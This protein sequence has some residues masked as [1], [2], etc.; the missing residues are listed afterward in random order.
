MATSHEEYFLG[1]KLYTGG[2]GLDTQRGPDPLP[3]C[4]NSS[5]KCT[6]HWSACQRS[7]Y[8]RGAGGGVSRFCPDKLNAALGGTICPDFNRGVVTGVS[9][10]MQSVIWT[11]PMRQGTVMSCDNK[12]LITPFP[13]VSGSLSESPLLVLFVHHIRKCGAGCPALFR[14]HTKGT[15]TGADKAAQRLWCQ[16][17]VV[18]V[19]IVE[20]SAF[21]KD[22]LDLSLCIRWVECRHEKTFSDWGCC[23]ID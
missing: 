23:T 11:R 16:D 10:W 3:D 1:P 19:K 15:D 21:I 7:S 12:T 20:C 5:T 13:W 2:G 14:V 17:P 9:G 6:A 22:D 8:T 4:N 18:C